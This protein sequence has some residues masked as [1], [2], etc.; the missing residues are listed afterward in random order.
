[1]TITKGTLPGL[2]QFF[3]ARVG[4]G[5]VSHLWFGFGKFLLKISNFSIFSLRVKKKSHQVESK[6]TWVKDWSPSYLLWV[7]SMIGSCQG[8]SLSKIAVSKCNKITTF[9]FNKG[10]YFM[11]Q[12]KQHNN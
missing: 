7:K 4:L 6:I 8:P 12:S 1:M 11:N 9:T 5:R 10:I 3:V 2:G